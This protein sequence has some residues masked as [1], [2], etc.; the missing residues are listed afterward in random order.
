MG[1]TKES[2]DVSANTESETEEE[3]PSLEM[4]IIPG[5]AE[6]P[7][8]TEQSSLEMGVDPSSPI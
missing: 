7:R 6:P 8:P 5:T 1:T 4:G 2:E 3:Q